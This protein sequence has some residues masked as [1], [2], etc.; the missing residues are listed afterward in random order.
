MNKKWMKFIV[1]VILFMIPSILILISK[2]FRVV[3]MMKFSIYNIIYISVISFLIYIMENFR[4][5]KT[6]NQSKIFMKLASGNL[7]VNTDVE[8]KTKQNIKKCTDIVE[9]LKDLYCSSGYNLNKAREKYK[10]LLSKTNGIARLFITDHT[11]KQI[12]NS[13]QEEVNESKL[14]YIGDRSYFI[15]AKNTGKTQISNYIFSKRQNNLIIVIAL[16]L[17]DDTEFRGIVAGTI[18]IEKVSHHMDKDKNIIC[19]TIAVFRNSIQNINNSVLK[20][21]KSIGELVSV[22]HDIEKSNNQIITEVEVMANRN[23]ESNNFIQDGK[24]KAEGVLENVN[25]VI[26]R[27]EGMDKKT[28]YLLETVING[29][30]KLNA[31]IEKMEES[32]A[33]L[34]KVNEI[35]DSLNGKTDEINTIIS[36][37]KQ[38]A[39]QTNLLS[40]NASIEAARAGEYGRGFEVVAQEIRTLAEQSNSEVEGIED[41]LMSIQENLINIAQSMEKTN[42]IL[43]E[44]DKMS[45]ETYKVFNKIKIATHDNKTNMEHTVVDAHEISTNINNIKNIIDDIAIVSEENSAAIQEIVSEIEQQFDGNSRLSDFINKT[46]EI[47]NSLEKSIGVFKC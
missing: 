40:L 1:K 29:E 14:M 22:N 32:K 17:Y 21:I 15:N 45:Q 12:F 9:E 18:D 42:L 46:K 23:M 7:N 33:L 4:G 11:G 3:G 20:L 8:G 36:V 41:V 31:L 43:N 35:V 44:E 47:G 26:F 13:Y 27:I 6:S 5:E 39:K 30:D 28:E 25:D 37:I 19:G 10:E 2:S 38:I 16:P 34:E 24:V